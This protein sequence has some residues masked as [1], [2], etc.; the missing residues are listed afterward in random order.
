LYVA[1]MVVMAAAC[2]KTAMDVM[3]WYGHMLL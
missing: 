2:V 3:G 1:A